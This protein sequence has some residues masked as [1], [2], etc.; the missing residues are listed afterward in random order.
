MSDFNPQQRIPSPVPAKRC[1][2]CFY[3]IDHLGAAG[4]CPECGAPFDLNDESTFT[5]HPPFARWTFWLPGLLTAVILGLISYILCIQWFGY[6]RSSA[7]GVP[8]SCG[9]LLGYRTRLSGIV[10]SLF[11]VLA[12]IAALML[13]LFT[14]SI[15]GAFCGLVLGGVALLPVIVGMLMG[16][17]LR[18]RLKRSSFSQRGYLPMLFAA[19]IVVAFIEGRHVNMPPVTLTTSMTFDASVQNTWESIQFYEQ[20][21]HPVPL[22]LRITPTFRPMYTIGAA[23]RVGDTK[24]CVYERGRLVKQITEVIPGKRLAFR[25]IEQTEIQNDGVR[26]I[27]GSFEL[28]PIPGTQQTRVT[29]STQYEPLLTPRLTFLPAEKLAVHTLHQHVLKGMKIDAQE[30]RQ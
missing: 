24:I 16:V 30:K 20:V 25:V 26:L 27:G 23:E 1:R 15:T 13:S 5:V 3:V 11:L 9:I 19:P 6:T 7:V 8:L 22:L 21:K 29:L 12:T 17:I 10:A 18:R 4:E 2:A 28:S 14:L